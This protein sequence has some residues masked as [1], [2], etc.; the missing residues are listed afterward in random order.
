MGDGGAAAV[1]TLADLSKPW[2][3]GEAPWLDQLDAVHDIRSSLQQRWRDEGYV[4]LPGFFGDHNAEVFTQD[5]LDDYARAW[6]A[7]NGCNACGGTGHADEVDLDDRTVHSGDCPKCAGV[8]DVRPMGWPYNTPYM[9]VDALRRL[10]CDS[11][12]AGVLEHLIGEPMAVHLNLTGW[13]STQRNW[14]Q[15]G[16]LNPDA[17]ADHYAAVWVALDDIDPHAGPFQYVPGSHRRFGV[18]RHDLM[19]AALRPDEQGPDWPTHSE[20][21]LTPLFEDELRHDHIVPHEFIAKRGDVLIWH[22]RLLHRGST[23]IDPTLERRALIAHYS[24]VHHRPDFPSAVR[25]D[26]GGWFFPI[27]EAGAPR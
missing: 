24:G 3:P 6:I 14:H 7:D 22:A 26:H 10:C 20:R 4:I 11:A 2:A 15:D 1:T 25:S 17:N 8:G 19:R 23:P 5:V 16:Y 12:L 18:I 21:I 13:R 27:Q 9:H